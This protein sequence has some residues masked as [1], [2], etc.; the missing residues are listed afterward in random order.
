MH[1]HLSAPHGPGPTFWNYL[2]SSRLRI[3]DDLG[4]GDVAKEI[5]RHLEQ[6]TG[7]PQAVK[8][9]ESSATAFL[10]T[11]AKQDGLGSLDFIEA[12]NDATSGLYMVREPDS[13]PLWA[14]AYALADYWENTWSGQKTINLAE[15]TEP[16]AFASIFLIGSGQLEQ[17]LEELRREGILDLYRNVPPYQV[18]RLWSDKDV[19]L[20]RLYD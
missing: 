14:F 20:E 6:S 13:P 12:T 11:Y 2:V 10:G 4:K 18:A 16:G 8:S 17:L 15:L 1:Y 3:G 5:A 9:V 7:K 19:V